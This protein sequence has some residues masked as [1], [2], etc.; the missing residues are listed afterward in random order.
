MKELLLAFIL[1]LI[2][3]S[4]INGWQQQQA[5]HPSAAGTA[6]GINPVSAGPRRDFPDFNSFPSLSQSNFGNLVLASEK[7]VFIVC[8]SPNNLSYERMVPLIAALAQE[9]ADS[10][11]VARLNIME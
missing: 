7:P 11:T 10:L 1:A 2:V 3:G 4:I 9:H 8:Y 6:G 5:T